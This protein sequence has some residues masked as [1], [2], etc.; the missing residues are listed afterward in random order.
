MSSPTRS[1]A[2]RLLSGQAG[3]L[4]AMAATM[5]GTAL[6]VGPPIFDEHMRRT[7]HG[8]QPEVLEHA[9]QAFRS[10]GFIS[11]AVGLTIAGVGA[12]VLSLLLTRRVTQPLRGL[13]AATH[14]V[15]SGDYTQ[16]VP[17]RGVPTELAEVGT[18]FNDMSARLASTESVRAR[19]LSDLAH[20]MRTPLAS[21]NLLV[22]AWE[23]GV[24]TPG[25]DVPQEI[26]RQTDRLL[27][28]TR[29]IKDIS[30]IEEGQLRLQH[31]VTTSGALL[32]RSR[33]TFRAA[34]E[35]QGVELVVADGSDP[36][37]TV[38]VDVDRIAQ[39][40]DNLVVNALRHTPAGGRVTLQ[41]SRDDDRLRIVVRDTGDGIE[42]DHLP[43]LFDRFY[44]TDTARD[45]DH[46]GSGIGLTISR[47]IAR[48]HGGELLAGSDGPGQGAAFTLLLPLG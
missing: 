40:L 19:M 1:L 30:E 42:A 29:D 22:E 28:L 39:V 20:E 31:T 44:R 33:E 27:R 9:D 6:I 7:G 47:A 13:A 23:D 16:Y 2:T 18:A 8:A 32:S 12:A 41:A 34:A 26:R 15:A 35:R 36:D 4:V 11:L 43:H 37:V 3:I 45:R 24:V 21:I 38:A 5:I 10:A 17:T 14:Q 46:G 48:A 25:T